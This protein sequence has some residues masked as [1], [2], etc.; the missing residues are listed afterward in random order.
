[1]R[2][3]PVSQRCIFGLS[4]GMT[5]NKLKVDAS[6][7]TKSKRRQMTKT[8]LAHGHQA[9]LVLAIIMCHHISD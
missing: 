7:G 4:M 8:I 5:S 3:I 2:I 1:M 9:L 6:M